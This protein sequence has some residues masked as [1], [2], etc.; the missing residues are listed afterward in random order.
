[1]P[2]IWL[3]KIFPATV[4][5][6]T[7]LAD[8]LVRVTKTKQELNDL[9]DDSADIFW[10]NIIERYCIKP[11][12]VPAVD[13]LCLAQFAAYYNMDYRKENIETINAQPEV[14]TDDITEIQHSNS[15]SSDSFYLPKKISLMNNNKTKKCRKTKLL[16]DIIDQIKENN[17]NCFSIIYLCYITRGGMNLT[18]LEVII[19]MCQNSME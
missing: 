4:F 7:D 3:R 17:L 15:N 5:V 16:S 18:S 10:S 11:A 1:M 12:S 6:E 8:K 19:H 2:E 9:D 13:N 14:L